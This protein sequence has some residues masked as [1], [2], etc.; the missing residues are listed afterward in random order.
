MPRDALSYVVRPADRDLFEGLRNG[1]FCYVLNTR[2]MGKSSL[3]VRAATR[4]REET[5]AIIAILDLTSIGQNLTPTQWYSGLLE[6]ITAQLG[7]NDLE[8][9]AE[10]FWRRSA[11]IGPLQRFFAALEKVILPHMVAGTDS[12]ASSLIIFVDEV[13]AARSLPFSGDEF[14]AGIREC[15]N[16]RAVNPLFSRLTFCLLGVA[17]P[18]DLISDVR[19]SPFNIGRRIRLTDFTATEAATL[20]QGLP[21]G[22]AAVTRVLYWTGGHP[23]LT[24][25]LLSAPRG[26]KGG[27]QSE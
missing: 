10:D 17:T 3:M 12:P 16:R 20:T 23:Y 6:Q 2:Q 1:D 13:D 22:A 19:M 7:D 5:G 4:L 18:A 25:R 9:A 15:Y 21:G 27:S 11:D 8:A 26:T 14:F 24:Q